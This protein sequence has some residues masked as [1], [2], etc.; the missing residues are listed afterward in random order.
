[1]ISFLCGWPCACDGAPGLARRT[2]E[3]GGEEDDSPL[4]PSSTAKPSAPAPGPATSGGEP[5][6]DT[7]GGAPP[8]VPAP[9]AP[10]ATAA[11]RGDGGFGD[12][13]RGLRDQPPPIATGGP[14]PPCKYAFCDSFENGADGASPPGWSSNG[15][16]VVDSTHAAFGKKSLRVRT[17]G[18][19][20][21]NLISHGGVFP[22]GKSTIY[23]RM[24]VW[25]EKRPG[26][27]GLVHWTGAEVRGSGGPTV[28]ALGGISQ[29]SFKNQNHLLFNIDPGGGEKALDDYFPT[30]SIPDKAWTCL[31]FMLTRG[32][33]GK[34]QARTWWNDVPR[35]RLDYNGT[36][37]SRFVFP[38]FGSL[39]IGFATYQN[40]GAFEL[41]ID[42]VAVSDQRVGCTP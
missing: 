38:T 6:D 9:R 26:S 30:P 41:Y 35:P 21:G 19:N 14:P 28:R 32:G 39:A 34:D 1:V 33:A 37:G 18:I 42:E 36:W 2:A 11:P 23:G 40:V 8:P 25:F 31:E 12:A 27:G 10:D 15:A 5:S 22:P 16:I 24:F 29:W 7:D 20:P 17:G 13:L 3:P 4:P